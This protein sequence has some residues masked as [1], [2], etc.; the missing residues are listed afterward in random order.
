MSNARAKILLVC[1]A[2]AAALAV[3]AGAFGSHALRGRIDPPLFSVYGTAVQYH[4]YHALGLF[5]AGMLADRLPQVRLIVWSGW[6]M[7]AGIVLFS[8]SLYAMSLFGARLGMLTPV[9]GAAFILG[10][11]FLAVGLLRADV[12]R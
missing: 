4:F 2:L 3:V 6:L 5:A 7:L 8:G 12:R 11:I 1:A 9:G 10:W